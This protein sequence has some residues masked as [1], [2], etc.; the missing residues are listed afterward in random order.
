M[1]AFELRAASAAA[2]VS[3]ASNDP[4]EP[5]AEYRELRDPVTLPVIDCVSAVPVFIEAASSACLSLCSFLPK[6]DLL[7]VFC[8]GF[9]EVGAVVGILL[10]ADA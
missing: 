5:L 6:K 10:A 2:L 8:L 9:S 3:S 4:I 7:A 1:P